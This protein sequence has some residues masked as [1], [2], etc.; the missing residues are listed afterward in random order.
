MSNQKL[1]SES[2]NTPTTVSITA[3]HK[4]SYHDLMEE[5]EAVK[6]TNIQLEQRIDD[7][8]EKIVLGAVLGFIFGFIAALVI[9]YA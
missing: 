8:T 7:R 3:Y 1:H 5:N 2:D 9:F 6:Q 4:R